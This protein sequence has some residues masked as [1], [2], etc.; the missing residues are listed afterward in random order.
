MTGGIREGILTISIL[1]RLN[2]LTLIIKISQQRRPNLPTR[3]QLVAPHTP[4]LVPFQG[5]EQQYFVCFRDRAA[6]VGEVEVHG[7]RLLRV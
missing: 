6:V 7:G 3:V 4:H 1:P 5:V 2:P